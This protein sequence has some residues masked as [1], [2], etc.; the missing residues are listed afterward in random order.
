MNGSMVMPISL[1][2][3]LII[4]LLKGFNSVAKVVYKQSK[5]R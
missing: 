3:N 2:S 5:T 4:R 1:F